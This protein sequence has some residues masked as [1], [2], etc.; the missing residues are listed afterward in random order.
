V[1]DDL[2]REGAFGASG[3]IDECVKHLEGMHSI[4][5]YPYLNWLIAR[6]KLVLIENWE[7]VETIAE[8]LIIEKRLAYL[9]VLNLP[10]DGSTIGGRLGLN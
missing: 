1:T 2:D 3:D 6:A 7:L 8:K 5:V 4:E 9:S 10:F